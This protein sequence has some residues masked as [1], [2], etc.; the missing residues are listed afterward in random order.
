[1]STHRAADGLR[2]GRLAGCLAIALGVGTS[3]ALAGDP[4][5][6]IDAMSGDL[7]AR[8]GKGIAGSTRH[9]AAFAQPHRAQPTPHR[10]PVVHEVLS[11]D[12]LSLRQAITSAMDGDTVTMPMGCSLI[13]LDSGEIPILV[14][15]LTLTGPGAD[16]FTIDGGQTSGFY[17]RVFHH[18]GTGTLT[19][20]GMTI[21]GATTNNSLDP[22]GGC[23]DSDGTVKLYETMVRNCYM[24]ADTGLNAQG[25]AIYAKLGVE[26]HASTVSANTANAVQGSTAG[27]GIFSNGYF[28]ADA[29][30]ISDNFAEGSGFGGG[31]YAVNGDVEIKSSTL[32]G[33]NAAVAGGLLV[34]Y[35]IGGPTA[36]AYLEDST[37]SGNK[38]TATVGGASFQVPA[39]ILNSTIVSNTAFD[40]ASGAG[41]YATT[42][43]S[44]TSSIFANNL[45]STGGPSIDVYALIGTIDGTNNII[46]STPSAT[47]ADTITAC[48]RLAPLSDNGGPTLTHEPMPGSPALDAGSDPLSLPFDQRGNGYARTFGATIDIG[49]VEWQGAPQ[50][51]LFASRFEITCD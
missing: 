11:C 1:M 49:A 39:T 36:I 42:T 8:I 47:P 37:V 21:S 38:A 24:Q 7:N 9:P 3:A 15:N 33:N 48:P 51:R 29:S 50:D 44:A 2:V 40:T 10:E 28:L 12:D 30:T 25:G 17:N 34:R 18:Y 20:S 16:A 13:S 27:G 41:V 23:I 26:L 6:A 19:I 4:Q 43:L 45:A 14:D 32:S 31:V 22:N 35:V 5:R 46:V